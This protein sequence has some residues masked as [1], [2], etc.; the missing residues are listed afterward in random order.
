MSGYHIRDVTPVRC[1]VIL[2]FISVRTY[3]FGPRFF[4]LVTDD[5]IPDY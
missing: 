1:E 2:E 4:S 5:K 3:R